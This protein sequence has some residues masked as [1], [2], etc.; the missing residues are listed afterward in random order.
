MSCALVLPVVTW[1]EW[2]LYGIKHECTFKSTHK[3]L[4]K[5]CP[6]LIQ[7]RKHHLNVKKGTIRHIKERLTTLHES[8]AISSM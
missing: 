5:P 1:I 2:R 6:V 7:Q 3:H 8:L 4:T